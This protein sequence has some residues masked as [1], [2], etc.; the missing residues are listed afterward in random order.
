M[1]GS[2]AHSLTLTPRNPNVH[3]PQ[4]TS[5]ST[6]K[7]Q[8]PK[9]DKKSPARGLHAVHGIRSA[10]RP[11]LGRSR[12][13]SSIGTDAAKALAKL[14]CRQ[15]KRKQASKQL[16]TAS[17]ACMRFSRGKDESW[18]SSR[19]QKRDN[20]A[21]SIHFPGFR[22]RFAAEQQAS[23]RCLF[24]PS[25][26]CAGAIGGFDSPLFVNGAWMCRGALF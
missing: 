11:S 19:T 6:G 15:A 10:C 5:A 16:E 4:V 20:P 13:S 18:R 21:K 9:M 23:P 2:R 25:L 22:L 7:F 14:S 12:S 8:K 1:H 24:L 3:H 17:C 26:L